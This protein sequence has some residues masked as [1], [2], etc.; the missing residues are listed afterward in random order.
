MAAEAGREAELEATKEAVDREP[1][2]H[3]DKGFYK[4][5]KKAMAAGRKARYQGRPYW[6]LGLLLVN[7]A[8]QGLGVGKALLAWGLD[9]ADREGLPVY[10]EATTAVRP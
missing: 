5:F 7:P 9:R 2:A 8:A 3:F 4:R 6:L 10:L 1:E